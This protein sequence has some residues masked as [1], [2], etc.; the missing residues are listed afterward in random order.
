MVENDIDKKDE[1]FYSDL[2]YKIKVTAGLDVCEDETVNERV[3]KRSKLI[4]NVVNGTPV[5]TLSD[6]ETEFFE[7]CIRIGDRVGVVIDNPY[8]INNY[9]EAVVEELQNLEMQKTKI[10]KLN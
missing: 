7:F 2:I 8:K 3:E 9:K 6:F 1:L 5:Y 10:K 4:E